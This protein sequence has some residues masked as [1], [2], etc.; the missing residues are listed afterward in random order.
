MQITIYVVTVKT[1]SKTFPKVKT[2]TDYKKAEDYAVNEAD[3]INA[4]GHRDG[5]ELRFNNQASESVMLT[6]H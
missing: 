3:K 1:Q 5:Y 4:E 2:F 6:I